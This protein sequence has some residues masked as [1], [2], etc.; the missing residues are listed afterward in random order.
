MS[1]GKAHI[2]KTA[3]GTTYCGRYVEGNLVGVAYAR[4]TLITSRARSICRECAAQLPPEDSD[5]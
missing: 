4:A 1:P 5:A 2:L 3:P